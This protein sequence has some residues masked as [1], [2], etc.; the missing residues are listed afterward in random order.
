MAGAAWLLLYLPVYQGLSAAA[1]TRD[2][3][4][5]GPLMLAVIFGAILVRLWSL[6]KAGQLPQ[7]LVVARRDVLAG[8]GSILLGSI[9]L[10]LGRVEQFELL[11]TASQL[12]M[13]A[14]MILLLGGGKLLRLLWFPVLM[15]F[16]LIVWPGWALDQVTAPLKLWISGFVADL[17][18]LFGLPV[19][20]S[21]VILA[22]GP[23]QL[24]IADACAGLNS[25]I[26][27][28]AVGALY[29][30]LARKPG[31]T[32]N[33]VV[34]LSTLPLAIFANIIRVMLLCLIT[35][36]WGYDAGQGFLHSLAGFVMF[37]VSLGGVFLVDALMDLKIFRPKDAAP[38]KTKP[39]EVPA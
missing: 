2:E 13:M 15:T 17:L 27:L 34:L 6:H 11:A 26:S 8:L 7:H 18:T 14:G 32:R 28:T 9:F 38:V 12:P 37:A 10:F 39:V 22:I 20:H 16:Y 25:L 35:Y 19:A 24:L 33:A 23:Y 3:N 1:W 31:M 29:L 21:G 5:H 36:F 30:Y 4:A